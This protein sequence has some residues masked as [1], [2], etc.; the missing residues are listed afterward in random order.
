M[1][2]PLVNE[3]GS[4]LVIMGL[5]I[6]TEGGG[7]IYTSVMEE[8]SIPEERQVIPFILIGEQALIGAVEINEQ[9]ANLVREGIE[10]DG[11]GWPPVAGLQGLFANADATVA[12]R[13]P[14]PEG[15]APPATA[16]PAATAVPQATSPATLAPTPPPGEEAEQGL[17]VPA[18]L[19]G[20]AAVVAAISAALFLRRRKTA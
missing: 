9:F 5:N 12:A 16:A 11:L 13:T 7:Q 8:L 17:P 4:R 19:G 14:A 18:L 20:G 3:Y 1:V 2:A 15:T 10:G 6:S